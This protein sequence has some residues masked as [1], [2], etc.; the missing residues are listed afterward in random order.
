M[1]MSDPIYAFR[2]KGQFDF[3]TCSECRYLKC[4][5]NPNLF[6]VVIFIRQEEL[7]ASKVREQAYRDEVGL[8]AVELAAKDA[9]IVMLRTAI[10]EGLST[11]RVPRTARIMEA[12]AAAADLSG[13]ILCDAYPVAKVDQDDNNS[14]AEI[15]PDID[16]RVGEPLYKARTK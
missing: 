4:V 2:R 9:E 14:W 12:L 3:C 6:E 5:A 1:E 11:Y 7:A 15:L 16:L 13:Y 10:E 8:M